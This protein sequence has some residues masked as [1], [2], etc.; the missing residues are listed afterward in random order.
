L[1]YAFFRAANALKADEILFEVFFEDSLLDL[2]DFLLF[3]FGFSLTLKAYA[4]FADAFS[5]LILSSG[6]TIFSETSVMPFLNFTNFVS[7]SATKWI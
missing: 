1:G 3:F 4:N 5:F 7:K 6:G 2:S